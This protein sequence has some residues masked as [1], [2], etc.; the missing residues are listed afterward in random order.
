MEVNAHYQKFSSVNDNNNEDNSFLSSSYFSWS[1]QIALSTS[2]LIFIISFLTKYFIISPYL[3]LAIWFI[4]YT[5]YIIMA[6]NLQVYHYLSNSHMMPSLQNYI[7][8]LLCQPADIYFNAE[9]YHMEAQNNDSHFSYLQKVISHQTSFPFNYYSCK[10]ISGLLHLQTLIA[11]NNAFVILNLEYEIYLFDSLSNSD[12]LNQK[13]H[14]YLDNFKRDSCS[15]FSVVK[16]I[17]DISINDKLITVTNAKHAL[18]NIYCFYIFTFMF[19]FIK[20]YSMYV[21][22]LC[23]KEKCKIAKVISTRYDL[24]ELQYQNILFDNSNLIPLIEQNSFVTFNPNSTSF[25]FTDDSELLIQNQSNR[26][27]KELNSNRSIEDI[28]KSMNRKRDLMSIDAAHCSHQSEMNLIASV[29]KRGSF[30]NY[31][32]IKSSTIFDWDKK[33]NI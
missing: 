25:N 3:L 31:P 27:I 16:S 33:K 32:L 20:L 10:D 6:F 21:E 1:A 14:F 26:S 13:Q 22:S 23:S 4:S 8:M 28:R 9:C 11:K 18:V 24:N 19:P 17:K 12:Y 29:K 7:E 15:E 30:N 2:S 5:V